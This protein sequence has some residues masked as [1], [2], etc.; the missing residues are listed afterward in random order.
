MHATLVLDCKV[1]CFHLATKFVSFRR[2]SSFVPLKTE[3]NSPHKTLRFCL[4]IVES[5]RS[6]MIVIPKYFEQPLSFLILTTI[7]K[8]AK[9]LIQLIRGKNKLVT[10]LTAL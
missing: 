5:I 2:T 9:Q 3:I 8:I 7:P 4:N 10:R 1:R 6:G